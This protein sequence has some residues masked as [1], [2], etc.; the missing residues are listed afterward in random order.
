MSAPLADDPRATDRRNWGRR[1]VAA[2]VGLMIAGIAA[3]GLV[4]TRST[5]DDVTAELRTA[6]ATG[7]TTLDGTE[8][9]LLF[10]NT[11]L[12]DS[13]GH[14][15]MVASAD[16]AGPRGVGDLQCE[17]VH[18]RDGHGICLRANRGAD[19]T[20]DAVLFDEA[21]AVGD[22]IPL[23]GAPSRARVS[24]GGRLAAAT[25]FVTGHTYENSG[26]STDTILID[27]D[28]GRVIA[29]IEADFTVL[30]DG[31]PWSEEDF[32]F[33]GVTFV[34]GNEFY[35]TL[36][37]GGISYLVAG[38]IDR[39]EMVVMEAGVECPSLSPDGLRLA[40]KRPVE[41]ADGAR[42]QLEVIDLE[43]RVVTVVA[44]N[45][46]VDDQVAWLDDDTI[47]YGLRDP[48]SPAES[49]TWAVPADGTGSPVLLVPGAWSTALVP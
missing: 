2:A 27:I 48:D 44:E 5:A 20:Y 8:P 49:D 3:I 7:E 9:M 17:R 22:R 31:Q 40:Y 16:P 6:L 18:Y 15:A 4:L 1:T 39:R 14:L 41:T 11:A 26:F 34:D 43:T 38:D 25:A 12:G 33:W 19:T 37:T 36:G 10:A 21:L 35:A 45:R 47:M 42:F 32:N 30:R 28:T 24:P 46:S 29:S 13:Y 23:A